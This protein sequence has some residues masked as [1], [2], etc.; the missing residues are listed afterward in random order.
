MKPYYER[1]GVALYHADYREVLPSL[2]PQSVDLVLTDPPYSTA[3]HSGARTGAR[4]E[5]ATLIPFASFTFDD[6]RT[7]LGAC[8]ALA[9]RW[10]VTFSDWRHVGPLVDETPEHLRFVRFG[11][12]V[13][14]NGAP[15]FTGDRPAQGWE[16]LTFWHR[17]GVKLRWHGRGRSSVWTVPKVHRNQ[18]PTQKPLPL[19]ADLV[20]LFSDPGDLVLDPFAGSGSTLVAALSEGR[21]ALGVEMD[22]RYCEI[23]AKRLEATQTPLVAQEAA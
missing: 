20:R 7:A 11:V 5:D 16:A 17:E 23:A 12:W 18:H 10:V 21:Q 1:D 4:G 2:A 14:P 19:L 3:T 9:R 8:G 6:L 22:E 15:Q 13:K